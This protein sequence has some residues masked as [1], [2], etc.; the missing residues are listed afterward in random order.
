MSSRSLKPS[1]ESR[2]LFVGAEHAD[3]YQSENWLARKL[4]NNFMTEVLAAV[5]AT[6]P[7]EVYEAGCGEGHILGL[8]A[9]NGFRVRGCDVSEDALNVANLEA[10]RRGLAFETTKKSIYDLDPSVDSADTVLCCEVFEHLEDPEAAL[11]NLLA[12]TRRFL[13]VSV[14]NEPLWRILNMVRGKYISSCG[15]TPGHI[16]H[17]STRRFVKF[18]GHHATITTVRR[19]IPWI[20]VTLQR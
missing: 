14:P 16:Q 8:L 4:V 6:G 9:S 5:R 1:V 2:D 3:K 18:L 10:A 20:L 17:W 13:I 15:N 7:H 11:K 12:I 19:P